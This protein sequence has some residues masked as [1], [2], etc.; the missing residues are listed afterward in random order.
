M[1]D[2]P[3]S[4]TKS[5]ECK[6]IKGIN[7]LY[8]LEHEHLKLHMTQRI[9][10]QQNSRRACKPTYSKVK[11]TDPYSSG[12][13]HG[14]VSGV[15]EFR[16]VIR[17]SQFHL[18]IFREVQDHDEQGPHVLRA[19]VHPCESLC[20]PQFTFLHRGVGR[21]CLDHAP[22][23]KTPYHQGRDD[24]DCRVEAKIYT[25]LKSSHLAA[26]PLQFKP[27]TLVCCVFAYL[28]LFNWTHSQVWVRI[29]I[30][31]WCDLTHELTPKVKFGMRCSKY[32]F[33]LLDA[34]NFF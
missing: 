6:N 19:D 2:G 1:T 27:T 34:E 21:F 25:E 22:G 32:V 7:Y 31:R 28:H 13:Q 5:W 10:R 30:L 33:S 11:Q 3:D 20:D 9:K 14:E 26:F 17:F 16:F 18:T 24:S 15:V 4:S 29:Y 23:D 12:K 8:T